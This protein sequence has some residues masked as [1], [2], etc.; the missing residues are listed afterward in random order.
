MDRRN[1]F[2]PRRLVQFAGQIAAALEDDPPEIP[3]SDTSLIRMAYRAMA[4][5]FEVVVPFGT[6]RAQEHGASAFALLEELEAQLTVYRDTSEVSTLNRIAFGRDVPVEDRLFELLQLAQQLTTATAGAFDISAGALIKAWGFFRGPKR[7][8]SDAE[9]AEALERVGMHWV[10]LDE[11]THSVRYLRS[12]LE[13]NLGAI[14]KGYALDRLH[15]HLRDARISAPVLLQG[16][17]SSVY[18]MGYPPGDPR[19]WPIDLCH[20]WAPGK[21]LG[22]VWLRDR[23]LGT[24]AA[25]FQHLEYNGQKLG[26]VLD[27]R[28]GWPAQGIASASVLAPTSALAD[29]LS[30]AFFVGGSELARSYCQSHP[31]V[32]AV[33][34]TEEPDAKLLVFG[35]TRETLLLSPD[36]PR[37]SS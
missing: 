12:G 6:P 13:I 9:R 36:G 27:P 4:T 23:A 1:F 35:Q 29:S 34:L 15:E 37:C 28:S 14:G 18:A 26:H 21:K 11:T 7:V 32:G 5:T 22:T 31:E 19:G 17:H 16:G 8:P 24:S 20:P 25:T 2:D 10:R 33:V 3:V 30:T